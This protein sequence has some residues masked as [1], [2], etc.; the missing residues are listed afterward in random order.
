MIRTMLAKSLKTICCHRKGLFCR[1][2]PF[3]NWLDN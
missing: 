1:S 2:N 3:Y